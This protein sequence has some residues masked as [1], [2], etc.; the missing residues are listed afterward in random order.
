MNRHTSRERQ[1]IVRFAFDDDV[2]CIHCNSNIRKGSRFNSAKKVMGEYQGIKIYQ[3]EMKCHICRNIL[4]VQTD[5]Q[6]RC[7]LYLSGLKQRPMVMETADQAGNVNDNDGIVDSFFDDKKRME[8]DVIIEMGKL[9]KE[10][11]EKSNK[12]ERGSSEEE[13][14]NV[15][16][17]QK[18]EKQ[19]KLSFLHML[20]SLQLVLLWCLMYQQT[21]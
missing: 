14:T 11:I 13:N 9:E 5:P 6:H 17:A 16:L 20:Q 1:I 21:A 19:E 12:S 15:E 10:R 4:V 8:K 18:R 7:F 2:V 3:F